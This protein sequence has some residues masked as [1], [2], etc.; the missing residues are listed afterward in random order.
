MIVTAAGDSETET[1][2][3]AAAASKGLVM[4]YVI[5]THRLPEQ[6]MAIAI[7]PQGEI[8]SAEA[9][10]LLR[11]RFGMVLAATEPDRIVVDLSAV[12]SISE[13]G[14]KALVTGYDKASERYA[15][16]EIVHAAPR[17]REQLSR[18]GLL[19]LIN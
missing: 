10:E 7:E 17:V 8:G 3:I 6:T 1:P 18:S 2:R 13:A 15:D 16:V 5:N 12:P 14:I 11:G 4:T 19:S 9:A